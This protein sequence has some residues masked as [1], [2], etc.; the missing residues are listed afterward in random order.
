MAMSYTS[1][2][3][4]AS[5]KDAWLFGRSTNS[6]TS[7]SG[8]VI[9][10]DVQKFKGSNITESAGTVTVTNN[11]LY[12][13]STMLTCYGTADDF[14]WY[15]NGAKITGVKGGRHYDSATSGLYHVVTMN[16]L[17]QL[18][19]SDTIAVYGDSATVYGTSLMSVFQGFMI[20]GNE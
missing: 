13:L 11:G 15:K 7:Y 9:D 20:G 17:E 3:I 2:G 6:G 14:D 10:F 18:G 1:V 16:T 5:S 4:S 8:A 12:Y 19:G